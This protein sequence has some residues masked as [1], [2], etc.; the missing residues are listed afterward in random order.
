M[1]GVRIV[2]L[3]LMLRASETKVKLRAILKA[4]TATSKAA[5]KAAEESADSR[6][7]LTR[8][9]KRHSILRSIM[10]RG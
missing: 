4:T 10:V 7:Q 1:A 3:R 5:R 6:I 8:C 2:L 9:D